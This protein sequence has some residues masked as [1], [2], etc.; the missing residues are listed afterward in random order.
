MPLT[1]VQPGRR[2]RVLSIE[3]GDGLQ[4]RLAALGLIPGVE[5]GVVQNSGHGPFLVEIM[6]GRVML[7]R[8]MANKVMVA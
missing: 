5:I 6:G 1:V 3:A 4:G 8:D 7:G 2:V